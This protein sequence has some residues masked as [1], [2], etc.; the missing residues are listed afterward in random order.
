M[1]AD[2]RATLRTAGRALDRMLLWNWYMVPNW[3][4]DNFHIAY[5]DRFGDPG[6]LIREEVQHDAWWVRRPEGD[7]KRRGARH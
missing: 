5:W 3:H 1:T 6:K 7:P 2:D 4:S